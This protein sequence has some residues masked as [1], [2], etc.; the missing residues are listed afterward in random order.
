MH[1]QKLPVLLPQ[2]A[3]RFDRK[4]VFERTRAAAEK[5]SAALGWGESTTSSRADPERRDYPFS[6]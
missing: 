4:T 1:T 6:D 2:K 3:A 5:I